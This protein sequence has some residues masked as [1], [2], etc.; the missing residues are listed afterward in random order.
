MSHSS[1]NLFGE[2]RIAQLAEEHE[3]GKERIDKGPVEES[4]EGQESGSYMEE[5]GERRS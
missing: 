2:L 5:S 1:E 3:K 4:K